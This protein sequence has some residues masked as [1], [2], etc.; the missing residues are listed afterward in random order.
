MTD[1]KHRISKQVKQVY[2]VERMPSPGELFVW[3]ALFRQSIIIAMKRMKTVIA[4]T[5]WFS[6]LKAQSA[7][8]SFKRILDSPVIRGC[9]D[10]SLQ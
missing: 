4:Q 7:L 8:E 2:A 10:G 5:Q 9:E 1:C 3:Y 6:V